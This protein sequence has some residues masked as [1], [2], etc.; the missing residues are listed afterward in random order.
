MGVGTGYPAAHQRSGDVVPTLAY[1][2]DMQAI[3]PAANEWTGFVNL[4]LLRS[5]RDLSRA[6]TL[7]GFIIPV[8]FRM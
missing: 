5:L 4:L 2:A 1:V 7:P 8:G 6:I 3:A